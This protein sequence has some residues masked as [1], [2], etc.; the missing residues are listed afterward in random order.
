MAG[1]R[2]AV[3]VVR[4]T[5]EEVVIKNMDFSGVD[6]ATGETVVS[7]DS[8]EIDPSGEMVIDQA[9]RQ[10]NLVQVTLSGGLEG[11]TYEVK[12]MVTTSEGQELEGV[13]RVSVRDG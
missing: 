1:I 13:G 12:V 2:T 5:P 10:G 6:L 3:E 7:I 9:T 11:R 4:K 8:T